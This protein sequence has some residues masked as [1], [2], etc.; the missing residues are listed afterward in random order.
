[1]YLFSMNFSTV[2]NDLLFSEFS[3]TALIYSE[4]FPLC[5]FM[6]IENLTDSV[7]Q[8]VVNSTTKQHF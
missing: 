6:V 7:L 8:V 2:G 1:M 5:F 4:F 3:L